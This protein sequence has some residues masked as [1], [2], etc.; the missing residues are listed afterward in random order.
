MRTSDLMLYVAY[1]LINEVS[2]RNICISWDISQEILN[3]WKTDP[4]FNSCLKIAKEHKQSHTPILFPTELR[5]LERFRNPDS[6]VLR[7]EEAQHEYQYQ[8]SINIEN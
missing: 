2:E 7:C 6:M 1:D 8:N 4:Q 3:Q 5:N